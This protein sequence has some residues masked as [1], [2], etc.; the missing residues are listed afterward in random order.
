MSEPLS[1]EELAA[2][3]IGELKR[4]D[5][6]VVLVEPDPRWP[7][8]YEAEAAAIRGALGARVVLLEHVG[9]TSIPGLMAKPVIDILLVVADPADEPA[10]VPA[11]EA[12]GFVL[13]IREPDWHQH[14]MFNGPR[15]KVNL[16]VF[17]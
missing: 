3:T 9:S 8:Q 17:G 2:V 4:L 11:L 1:D 14:R 7:A 12:A 16:H 6:Q 13:K 15:V 5:G 10:Y